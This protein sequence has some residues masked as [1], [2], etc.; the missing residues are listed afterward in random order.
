MLL[1]LDIKYIKFLE[2]ELR[3]ELPLGYKNK[4]MNNNGGT[5]SL[6]DEYWELFPIADTSTKES[7]SKT[8]NHVLKETKEAFKWDGFL[9]NYLAIGSNID[10]DLLILLHEEKDYLS[11]IFIWRQETGV[12]SKIADCFSELDK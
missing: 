9:F 8:A 1:D 12:I 11:D 4:I 2:E 6:D 3:L 7:I 10:G 5:I